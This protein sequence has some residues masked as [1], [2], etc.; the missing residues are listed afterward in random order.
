MRS[1][2]RSLILGACLAGGLLQ[3][4]APKQIVV[5]RSGPYP[6]Y[7][8]AV[9]GFTQELNRRG[10]PFVL[11]EKILPGEP[12]APAFMESLRAA[13]PDLLFT[14]GT[15]ATRIAQEK[16]AGTPFVYAMIVD[17][18]SLGLTGGGAVMEV[19]PSV[20][21]AF[22]HEN[23]PRLRRVGVIHSSQRNRETVRFFREHKGAEPFLVMIQADTP[24]EMSNAIQKL[25]KE[26]D[27]LLMVSD[28]VLYSPQ[29]ATQIILQTL[30][31]N[32]PFFAISPSFVKAGALAA[33]YPDYEDNGRLAA[34]AAARHF[35]GENVSGI[36]PLWPAKTRTAVNLIVAKRLGIPVPARV[37]S[38]A[39]E[40]VR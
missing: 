17:P 34:E 40:V 18:S 15:Q 25:S 11:D 19:L 7:D 23:F 38:S 13:H 39:E 2:R 29:T 21:L 35:A 20:H 5:L 10:I 26:A 30:Q 14:I 8:H 6:I 37:V 28:A 16:G 1:L 36:P 9:R 27:C 32:L 22:I 24:E 12:E 4:A 3:A 31:N 33:V